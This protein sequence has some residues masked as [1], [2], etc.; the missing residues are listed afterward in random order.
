MKTRLASA[1]AAAAAFLACAAGAA[2]DVSWTSVEM[3]ARGDSIATNGTLAYAWCQS[4]GGA[5]VTN[6][7][8]GVPFV[9]RQGVSGCADFGLSG[10]WYWDL[11]GTSLVTLDVAYSNL[12]AHGWWSKIDDDTRRKDVDLQLRNLTPGATY[13][14]QFILATQKTSDGGPGNTFAY[15]PGDGSVYARPTGY[16]GSLVGTFIAESATESFTIRYEVANAFFNA[17][18]V[19]KIVSGAHPTIGSLSASTFRRTATIALADVGM[20]TDE[21]GNP[22]TKYS[23]SYSLNDGDPVTVLRDRTGETA[24]F[25]LSNL[26]DGDYVCTVVVESDKGKTSLPASVSFEIFAQEG[27][28]DALKAAIEGASDGDTIVVNRG[29]YT[30]TSA[31]GVT[32]ANLTVVSREGASK[33]ILDGDSSANL[34]RVSASGFTVRGVTFKNGSS[35]KGGA[36]RLDGSAAVN[37]ATIRDCDFVDCTARFGGAIYAFDETHADFGARSGYGLVDGC[38]FV[39]CGTSHTDLWNAGGAIYGS[40]WIENSVFDA[41]YVEPTA[42]RG[43]TSVAAT[44]HTTVSNCVFRNQTLRSYGGGLAGTTFGSNN[45][46]CPNGAVRLVGCTIAGNVLDSSNAGL[47]YD[48]VWVDRCVVSNT[49]TTIN[50]SSSGNNLPSFY[51]SPDA[52]VA[53]VTSTLFVDNKFPFKLG[54]IPSLAN[55]TFVR[56]VGGLAWFQNDSSVPAITN[57]VFWDNLPKAD[58][59]PWGRSYK[60]APGLYWCESP[61]DNN[62]LL[63][64]VVQ[65]ANT[66]VEGGSTNAVAE[67]LALDPSGA[68]MRI[69]D[70]CDGK[71]VLFTAPAK[72]DW[73]PRAKSPL[74]NAGAPC[75]WMAG[76]RDFAGRPRAFGGAPDVGCYEHFGEPPTILVLR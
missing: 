14:V 7:V 35:D 18:Q 30:A 4:N 55:C 48:R 23:V 68:S 57:C 6:T 47:F 74:T 59:W 1:F 17:L 42:S 64:S 65:I 45:D 12:L 56:N 5:A 50:T 24:E 69:T 33:T 52:A 54:S 76:A 71:G 73:R 19:R 21:D 10:E 61:V 3:D 31:I 75:G 70:D 39:R 60:G 2:T 25:V 38:A 8:N 44:G 32:A 13:L 22:A 37:T 29:I 11:D 40:L 15:A 26:P 51:R 36:I 58:G 67:V 63:T 34:L 43:Q 66:V 49:T 28:F 62:P 16:G 53:K 27:N 20:G 46:D 9:G 41:C 72:N